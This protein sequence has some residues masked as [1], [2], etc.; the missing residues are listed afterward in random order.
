MPLNSLARRYADE[1]YTRRMEKIVAEQ[2]DKRKEIH[3]NHTQ[4]GTMLS[5]PFVSAVG[6]N[7]AETLRLLAEARVETLLSAY[8]K[9]GIPFDDSALHEV[10]NEVSQ[11]CMTQQGHTTVYLSKFVN[12]IFGGNAPSNMLVSITG[13]IEAAT[14]MI[15][16]NIARDLR[17]KR[18]EIALSEGRVLKA[19]GA[20]LG[21]QWDVFISYASEDNE[22]FV[23][24][25]AQVLEK[26]GLSV[27][28]APSTLT[29]GDRLRK[30]IDEGIAKSRF[31]IVVLSHNFFA[32]PWPQEELEGL[33]SKE[34][35]G[36]KVILP[37]W[38]KISA[39]EVRLYSPILSGRVAVESSAGLDAV[40]RQLQEAMGRTISNTPS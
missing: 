5:G 12:Q 18:Y 32:K 24:P 28:Y 29:V 36:V 3:A 21:K 38:H 9:A 25:L 15:I 19:Y 27:W 39:S 33:F 8:E 26:S 20:A 1:S 31:G 37:V 4:R 30:T 23:Q 13:Q 40:V 34:I 16:Q 35:E 22:E 10:T 7:E 2:E 17:I 6:R 11:F 14:A